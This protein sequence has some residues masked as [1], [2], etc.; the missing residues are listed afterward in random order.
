MR[1]YWRMKLKDYLTQHNL[2]QTRFAARI[3]R[4]VSAVSRWLSGVQRPSWAAL[5]LISNATGGAVMPNDF[6]PNDFMPND[7]VA[8]DDTGT[9]DEPPQA[10]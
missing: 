7:V 4:P 1:K 3:G 2:S 9:T 5:E 6:M 8:E 10:A